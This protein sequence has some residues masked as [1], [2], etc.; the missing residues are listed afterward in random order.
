M[1]E[2][3]LILATVVVDIARIYAHRTQ[4]Q[5]IFV[6]SDS[7]PQRYLAKL[8]VA[9]ITKQKIGDCII[10]DEHVELAVLIVVEKGE[11]HAL[12]DVICDA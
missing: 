3:R 9:F 5:A 10:G 2:L 1:K 7:S 4:R 12:P 11:S 6:E 8:T